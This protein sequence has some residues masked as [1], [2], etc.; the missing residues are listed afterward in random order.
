MHRRAKA[1]E[2]I[3]NT[4]WGDEL[5]SKT[6]G[7]IVNLWLC[8]W[9]SH[10]VWAMYGFQM[11]LGIK[12]FYDKFSISHTGIIIG[13]FVGSFALAAVVMHIMLLLRGLK[14]LGISLPISSFRLELRRC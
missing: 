13:G 11:S 5:W 14:G 12:N 4:Y 10:L 2:P 9:R 1:V 7:G 8:F 3:S 6:F